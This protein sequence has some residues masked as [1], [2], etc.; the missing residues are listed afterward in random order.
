MSEVI[1][2]TTELLGRS[3]SYDHR[4]SEKATKARID[5]DIRGV[6]VVLPKGS[7]VDPE[8]LLAENAAWV[9][10]KVQEFEAYREQVPERSFRAGE[11]FPYLNESHE[12]AIE[13]RP[14]SRIEDGTI[15]LAEHHVEQT[16]IKR[17]LETLYRRKA[18]ERFENRADEYAESMGV[19]YEKIEIRNQRTKWGSCSTS[20]TLGLNWRL[21]MAPEAVIDYVIVHELGHLRESNHTDAFWSLVAEYDPDYEKHAR[22]LE[23]N[24]TQL[25]FSEDDL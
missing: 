13:Q 17:A 2:R 18:R 6:T 1:E 15:R 5:V 8:T 20:G 11:T 25:I 24:S 19:E 23:E 9:I 7:S 16:S 21:M 3:V 10:E 22:W 14:S 4:W 12:V